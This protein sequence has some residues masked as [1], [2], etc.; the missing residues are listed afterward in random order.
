MF[1]I[2]TPVNES[3]STMKHGIWSPR[4]NSIGSMLVP[5]VMIRPPNNMSSRLL[6]YVS[7][8]NEAETQ[9]ISPERR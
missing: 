4:A 7:F 1:A 3:D 6:L 5:I 9:P 8:S 2:A